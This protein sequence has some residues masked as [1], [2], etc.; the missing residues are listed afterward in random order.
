MVPARHGTRSPRS[1][2]WLLLVLALLVGIAG[3][4]GMVLCF[5]P[6][7]HVTLEFVGAE[8]DPCCANEPEG[9]DAPR[10]QSLG[11]CPCEDF[12]V[13]VSELA[14][15]KRSA[16]GELLAALDAACVQPAFSE[17][18]ELGAP[19]PRAVRQLELPRSHASTV[20]PL[21]RSVVL[22]V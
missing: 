22:V 16:L 3:G 14:S 11:D 8:C 20:L 15:V 6:D 7:G 17:L 10:E 12:V 19:A 9:S 4:H 21:V 5:E 18:F 1:T 2:A 13:S